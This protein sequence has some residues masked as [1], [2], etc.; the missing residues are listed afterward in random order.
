MSFE[1]SINILDEL[2]K[3]TI[4]KI[5]ENQNIEWIIK[6]VYNQNKDDLNNFW[7][8]LMLELNFI[9]PEV[10]EMF[11]EFDKISGKHNSVYH[12]IL[13]IANFSEKNYL[14]D[15]AESIG[16]ENKYGKLCRKNPKLERL[17]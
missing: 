14:W 17:L 13:N 1:E 10:T 12:Y 16:I 3:T 8:S 11:E 6:S 5:G 4:S 9:D 7:K 15:F 2:V